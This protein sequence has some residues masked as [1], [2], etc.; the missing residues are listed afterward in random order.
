MKKMAFLI[1]LLVN[2]HAYAEELVPLN[3]YIKKNPTYLTNSLKAEYVANRC[4]SLM[5]I[6]AN[7]T[8]EADKT[9]EV[10]KLANE[11]DRIGNVYS[12]AGLMLSKAPVSSEEKY[13]ELHKALLITYS[14]LTL[15]NWKSGNMFK[16]LIDQDFGT[17]VVHETFYEKLSK[18]L[19]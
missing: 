9:K 3:I 6:L 4:G 18:S 19:K 14:N 2:V 15:K 1:L 10:I 13:I 5:T 11:Y 16:G 12:L 17:C 7:R 8:R